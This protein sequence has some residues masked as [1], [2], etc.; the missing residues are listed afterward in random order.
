MR[1]SPTEAVLKWLALVASALLPVGALGPALA[2][3]D[4]DGPDPAAPRSVQAHGVSPRSIVVEFVEPDLYQIWRDSLADRYVFDTP[5]SDHGST[6]SSACPAQWRRSGGWQ[7]RC[8]SLGWAIP[9]RRS[10]CGPRD[11]HTTTHPPYEV[12]S[13][14]LPCAFF[15]VP[16][17]VVATL[18]GVVLLTA[19]AVEPANLLFA[20][21]GQNTVMDLP[22]LVPTPTGP[23]QYPDLVISGVETA[24]D[25][26][27]DIRNELEDLSPGDFMNLEEYRSARAQLS[28]QL[29][30][31]EKG[32]GAP[33]PCSAGTTNSFAVQV[34]EHR[35][36]RHARCRGSIAGHRRRAHRDDPNHRRVGG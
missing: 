3:G 8:L 21:T 24:G 34:R 13:W 32:A 26:C 6:N 9:C 33:T 19:V 5:S 15:S 20:D 18:T 31:C 35:Q 23:Y 12:Q 2:D 25:P 27:W 10:C 28:Q 17:C 7:S 16:D 36:G 11:G 14:R 29:L 22:T 30:A 1:R 4:D